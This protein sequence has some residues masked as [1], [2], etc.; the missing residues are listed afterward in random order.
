MSNKTGQMGT[1]IL[2]L[3]WP[4]IDYAYHGPGFI[5]TITDLGGGKLKS[6]TNI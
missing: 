3:A 5:V 2:I 1:M 4:L 6:Y